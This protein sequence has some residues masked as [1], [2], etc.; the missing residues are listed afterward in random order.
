M[1]SACQGSGRQIQS[2]LDFLAQMGGIP[3]KTRDGLEPLKLQFLSRII[4]R[5]PL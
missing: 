1:V 5:S 3:F 4:A 2:M